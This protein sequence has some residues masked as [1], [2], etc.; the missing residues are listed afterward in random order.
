[1]PKANL[2]KIKLLKLVELFRLETD[3]A[4]PLTTNEVC[5]RLTR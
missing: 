4:H 2:Q 3:E 1:M 5:N